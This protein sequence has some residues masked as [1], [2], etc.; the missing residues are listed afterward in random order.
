M[1]ALASRFSGLIADLTAGLNAG[2]FL[3]LSLGLL[4][5]CAL[6]QGPAAVSAPAA[7]TSSAS[8][9]STSAASVAPSAS[10]AFLK[11]PPALKMEGVPP[12]PQSLVSQVGRYN[13]FDSMGLV[14]WHP[15]RREL[16]ISRRP[17]NGNV[18]QLWRLPSPQAQAE[19]LT[20]GDE[21]VNGASYEPKEGR[22]AVVQRAVGGNEAYQVFRLDL[23][24]REMTLLTSPQRRH[25]FS[26]W[27][28]QESAAII[29]SVPLD[30]VAGQAP[31]TT[32]VWKMDP[33]SPDSKRLV[34]ELAG[35]GWS[36]AAASH[37]DRQLVLQRYLSANASEVWLMDLATGQQRRVLPA[38][39]GQPMAT[40]QPVTFTP[41]DRQLW[42]VSDRASEFSE[43]MRWD[44]ATGQLERM[45]AQIPWDVDA[46]SASRDGA[47]LA[48]RINADG[49]DELRVLDART[50]LQR[51]LPALPP[52]SVTRAVFHR[53]RPELAFTVN[54][55]QSPNQLYTLDLQQGTI[56]SWARP[57]TAPGMTMT[58]QEIVRW[59][60]FDGRTISGLINRPP[61]GRFSGKRPVLISIHGGPESQARMG[62]AGR[63]NYLIQ[64]LGI[65]VIQPN[66]RGSSG[67]G[68]TFLTLDNGKLREDSVKD[69]GA[70]FDWIAQQPDLDASRVVVTGG[71][72]GG[73]MSL[74]VAT[75]YA[76][77][78]A[79]S[80]DVVGIS[81]FVTFLQ[82]TETYRR[83]LRR[84]EYGDERDPDMRAHLERIS[85][86]TNAD[87]IRKPLFVVH[88]KNDPRV[89]YTEAEQI[90]A[91]VR[92]HGTPVWYLR[93]ENEGH[94]FARKENADYQFYATVLFLRQVMGL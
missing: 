26:T 10:E 21:P 88:G 18:S 77:R 79:G 85:P 2:L 87:R 86:L 37:D 42:V 25:Q 6:P 29:T 93:A 1:R 41:D 27:L 51:A 69:I 81:H 45:T 82:N 50:G 62:F 33:L 28:H 52:G 17:A 89:P 67:Y 39:D 12:I 48:L 55:A 46:V 4:G 30:R 5:G 80:I 34:A 53:Q 9:P 71:S 78:I 19:L 40:Y 61:A 15:T 13:G 64:E 44:L 94:G 59:T 43:L 38:G 65:T 75:H 54:D 92:S 47:W 49:R 68:K 14:G 72:Y 90:V 31:P 16:L 91:R 36:V 58:Q 84:V 74:A 35:T 3:P 32:Q 66:V 73:Y 22:Y 57:R 8:A 7:P 24:T 63:T 23:A 70:L 60:S 20:P 83:D 56:E 11:P 76:D